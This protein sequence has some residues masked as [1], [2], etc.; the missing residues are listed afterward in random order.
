MSI[1]KRL[2]VENF[3]SHE[4]SEVI[5]G[6]GLN[7]I[8]GPSDFGKSA[9]VRA[10]R[11]LFYNEPRG[12]NFIS[13][14]ARTCRVTVELDD[15][16][17]IARLRSTAGKKENQYILQR[18]GE[19]EQV[20]VDLREIPLE[21]IRAL[22]VRK[23]Q[24]DEHNSV[25]LNFGAQLDGPFL[26]AENGAVR[27]KVIGQLGGVHI[28][29]WAQKST[30][31]DL[32]RLREEEGQLAAG[33]AGIESALGAYVHLT[34]LETGIKH[35]EE[36]V[37][38]IEAI[39]AAVA[40]LEE[41]QH[42][43]LE[44]STALAEADRTLAALNLLEQAE[45]RAQELESMSL[46]Y[47]NLSA[48][49]GDLGQVEQQLESAR[50]RIASL[51]MLGEA[52]QRLG[53]LETLLG[54]YARLVQLAGEISQ[55]AGQLAGAEKIAGLTGAVP[56]AESVAQRV[57]DLYRQWSELTRAAGDLAA[58]TAAWQ[59]A[60]RIT[61]R[62]VH[63]ERIDSYLTAAG[64]DWQKLHFL[65]ELWQDWQ[66]EDRDYQ[67][68]SLAAERYQKEMEQL[69]DDYGKLL[70]RLGRCPVCFGDLTP[71]AVERALSEY[72]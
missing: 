37:T 50:G 68:A 11:W 54:D 67:G 63:L 62:T 1:L 20:Y 24:V 60:D 55:T 35:L 40:S 18:P 14:W 44:S 72:Q 15:G 51:V 33:V 38:R 41:L 16:A 34:D 47:R 43:W 31:T 21:I 65:S 36:K 28:L 9:L 32:R 58:V 71:E 25:E 56:E 48:I 12:A 13:V 17:K 7:V 39:T 69:L 49:A 52:E 45:E 30:A 64:D 3:Q 22:D 57:D 66:E 5:F 53:S 6:P 26:L 27:A 2:V 19:S 59:D 23:V 42:R 10:L 70:L 8:V 29:D 4:H 46:R 61:A